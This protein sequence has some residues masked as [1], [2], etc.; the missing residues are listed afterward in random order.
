[1]KWMAWRLAIGDG[2]EG[3]EHKENTFQFYLTETWDAETWDWDWGEMY[4][5]INFLLNPIKL[6]QFP[7][8]IKIY[9]LQQSIWH[10]HWQWLRCAAFK[11]VWDTVHSLCSLPCNRLE[12]HMHRHPT[13]IGV[14]VNHSPP[15][16]SSYHLT[17]TTKP[18]HMCDRPRLA[19]TNPL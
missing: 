7:I 3:M 19:A 4:I 1:M 12:F 11:W 13:H 8:K 14:T 6:W 5:Y 18:T 2:M 10:S 9:L 16:D 17:I 15:Q